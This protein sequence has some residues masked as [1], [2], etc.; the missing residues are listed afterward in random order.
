MLFIK[1]NNSQPLRVFNK[2]KLSNL[3]LNVLPREDCF[4]TGTAYVAANSGSVAWKQ[5]KADK[6]PFSII[7]QDKKR[8]KHAHLLKV[9][10]CLDFHLSSVITVLL[11]FAYVPFL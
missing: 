4:V 1:E 3:K 2:S 6:V 7:H 8:P 9:L 10:V 5:F 11:W